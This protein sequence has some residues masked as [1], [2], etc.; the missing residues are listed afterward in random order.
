L[1]LVTLASAQSG[2]VVESV[3]SSLAYGR[4][5]SS[6]V[7][8]QNLA[9]IPAD[10][11]VEAHR[12][13][14]ALVPLGERMG[15][16]IHLL[17]EEQVSFRLQI[18]EE[19][20]GAWV[21]VREHLTGRTAPAVAVSGTTECHQGNQLRTAAREVAYPTRNPWFAGEIAELRGSVVSLIN[22]SAATLRASLC[23]SA[24]NLFSVPGETQASRE[25]RPVCSASFE[26]QVPPFGTRNF[27]V[28][29]QGSSYFSLKTQGDS[30][31][32]QMLRP[33]SEGV[34]I[35]TVDSTIR[36]GA[37]VPDAKR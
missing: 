29:R 20:T 14:G 12:S 32:L 26:V 28:E 19:E 33:A 4:S 9:D 18:H 11:D 35:Y 36:F 5:C 6:T 23:Y 25:L 37:E 10:L 15:R 16:L 27:P 2:S 22:V 3:L 21:K 30:I 13:S 34:Q 24:G 1:V 7:V 17:P 31:V 8:L